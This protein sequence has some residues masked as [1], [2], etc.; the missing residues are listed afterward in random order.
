MEDCTFDTNSASGAAGGLG[1]GNGQGKGGAIYLL[2]AAF[3]IQLNT[4]YVGN[5]AADDAA[6]PGDDED[7]FGTFD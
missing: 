5:L 3:A 1:A 7:V 4:T 6:V 2:P